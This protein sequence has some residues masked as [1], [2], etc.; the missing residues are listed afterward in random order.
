MNHRSGERQVHHQVENVLKSLQLV[1]Q[2]VGTR[3]LACPKH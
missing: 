2:N 3:L 1:L